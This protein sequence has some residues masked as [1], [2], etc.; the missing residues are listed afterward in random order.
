[1]IESHGELQKFFVSVEDYASGDTVAEGS[2][3]YD[4]LTGILSAIMRKEA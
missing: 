3:E 1:M 2:A 4:R